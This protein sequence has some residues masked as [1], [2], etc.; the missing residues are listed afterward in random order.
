MPRKRTVSPSRELAPD[1]AGCMKCDAGMEM[2][3]DFHHKD[4]SVCVVIQRN[5]GFSTV[6]NIPP[7]GR[8]DPGKDIFVSPCG[9]RSRMLAP[10][11]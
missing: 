5:R 8:Y 11:R 9:A 4:G 6:E 2:I 3:S 10:E 1:S 7:M